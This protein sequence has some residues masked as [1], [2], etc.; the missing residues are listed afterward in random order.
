VGM[1]EN[2]MGVKLGM[3]KAREEVVS[4]DEGEE[5]SKGREE[6]IGLYRKG[7]EEVGRFREL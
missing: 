5:E 7:R 3:A 6:N 4:F 2:K 1:L